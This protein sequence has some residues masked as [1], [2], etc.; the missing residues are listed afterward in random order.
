MK[1]VSIGWL[2]LVGLATA[3]PAM[4]QNA[5]PMTDQAK[6]VEALVRK[7]AALVDKEGKAAFT[8]LRKP[9]SE[10]FHGSTY[11][12]S[13][14][15]QGIVLLQPAF[16]KREGANVGA[17]GEK[18]ANGKLFHVAIL[19]TADKRGEG[20]VDYMFPKPGQTVPSQKWTFV[21]KVVIDGTP[22]LVGSG[23]YP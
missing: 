7:A 5:P 2:L 10:W 12:F 11:V 17:S 8:E 20:W 6:Q 16:P 13:Y 23:F 21:K 15:M 9:D 22:G 19:E 1:S 14:S 4:A 18:D 3:T